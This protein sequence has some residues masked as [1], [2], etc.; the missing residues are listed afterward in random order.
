MA[1]I[2]QTISHYKVLE[3]LGEGGMGVVYKAQDTKLLR[4][5]A[6]KFLSA[7]MTR[8]QDAK[9]R[10]IQEA[11]AASALDHPNIAVVHD[12]DETS[13]GHSFICMAYY[14]GQTLKAK[15][16]KGP[17]SVDESVNIA[18]Q[19]A[20][21]LQR[22]HESRIIHRDIKPGNI[23]ITPQGE[24]KIVD[25]GLAKLA[26][27][28]HITRSHI[29][30]GTSAYMA[31]EQ[32][33]GDEA[34]ARS[35]LFSLGVV[36]YE[37]VVGRRPFLGEHEPALFY[38]IV[39][40]EPIP[41]SALQPGISQELERVILKL[42]AKEPTQRYQS[43]ADVRADLK[44]FLGEEPT[45]SPRRPRSRPG[46]SRWIITAST[47]VLTGAILLLWFSTSKPALSLSP[48]DY[49]LVA[50]FE[51]T[52]GETI[53]DQSLTEAMR[54]SL[55]QS[56]RISLLSES[57]VQDA[58]ARMQSA[59][60][61]PLDAV[62]ALEVARREGARIV[63]AGNI[64]RVGTEYLLT[65][66]IIDAVSGETVSIRHHQAL[67]AG[68]I[69]SRLDDLCRDV[70]EALGESLHEIS[71]Y[72]SPLDKVTTPSLEALALYSRGNVLEGQGNYS[73]A[74]LL[75]EQAVVKDSLFVMAIS[76]VSYIHRKLRNDSL[77]LIFH[78]R[79]L[80]LVNRVSDRERYYI[81]SLY[82]GPSFEYDFQTA[83]EYA[84]KLVARY[85]N[86]AEG[87]A[88]LGWLAMRVGDLPTCLS[89]N[90]RSVSAD[91]TYAGTCY[92]NSGFAL[93]MIG[94]PE[95][96]LVYF[97]RSKILRPT[98][99]MIDEYRARAFWMSLRVDSAAR[100]F[101]SINALNSMIA[102]QYFG[103]RLQIAADLCR[104]EIARTTEP[105]N[106]AGLL[107]LLS[108]IERSRGNFALSRK[109]LMEALAKCP[110]SAEEF[111]L[112][113]A[114]LARSGRIQEAQ[115]VL[116]K[117]DHIRSIDPYFQKRKG[118]YTSFVAGSIEM[119]AGKLKAS[120]D[121]F[122][123]VKRIQADDVFFLTAQRSLADCYRAQSETSA[124]GIYQYL[125]Q[126]R[127]EVLMAPRQPS[128]HPSFLWVEVQLE[129]AK[130][131]FSHGRKS[132]ARANLEHLQ[133]LWANADDNYIHSREVRQLLA[134]MSQ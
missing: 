130:L 67:T 101:Q 107:H 31:P 106:Q 73:E 109:V 27:Q 111:F 42:L 128:M 60:K 118:D 86:S 54:V 93:A 18:L 49:V 125:L 81:L 74:A 113:G 65:C 83:F 16:A 91:S 87:L 17:M 68:Q 69:I 4:P 9:K 28:S 78:R 79:V 66:R 71:Q 55:R 133:S 77:A 64:G 25:F 102:L 98:F 117:I 120:I 88:M 19:I 97:N 84:R 119:A 75:K 36:L 103:G 124:I 30:G 94:K 121:H 104:A 41:P 20:S 134:R 58:L 114:S 62:T 112:I 45:P 56:S 32:I 76:D 52:T 59:K 108:F 24:V 122:R 82:Y 38:S 40:T 44:R 126:K 15:L 95:E 92:N 11:R 89:A 29:T 123:Q 100:I 72:S 46:K 50:A 10:F 1:M 48:N 13:D 6:L 110:T 5:V 51:N 47:I 53:F 85:P 131:L 22:A 33:L 57:R 63:L 90:E 43:A 21:G 61:I 80:P 12:I 35:D 127:G 3:K 26:V 34:D 99:T 7:D 37:A 8:D 129:L 105:K 70:R 23:I 2:G 116:A 39:N 96:A 115:N 132:E 14:E